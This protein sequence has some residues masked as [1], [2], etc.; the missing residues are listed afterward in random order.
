MLG[1]RGVVER[2]DRSLR[3]RHRPAKPSTTEGQIEVLASIVSDQ[4]VADHVANTDP[5]TQYQK[6]TEKD[7]AGGYLGADANNRLPSTKVHMTATDRLLGRS[8]AGAGASEEII[9][10]AAARA[11]LDDA[12]AAAMRTTLGAAAAATTRDG[13]GITDVPLRVFNGSN[14]AMGIGANWDF[15]VTAANKV[16]LVTASML[17]PGTDGEAI[18]LVI[19]ESNGT[20]RVH[21]LFQ[22]NMTLTNTGTT[23]RLTNTTGVV[24]DVLAQVLDLTS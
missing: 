18:A 1:S 16:Y 19:T 17:N 3:S 21:V 23:L 12:T 9:A 24:R 8:T 22:Q 20:V 7:V 6:E 2:H 10:T 14:P 5:H 11:L 15:Y 4:T 13:Y